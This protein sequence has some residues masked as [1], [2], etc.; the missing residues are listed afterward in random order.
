MAVQAA[1]KQTLDGTDLSHSVIVRAK[2][3]LTKYNS[4]SEIH[5]DPKG[6]KLHTAFYNEFFSS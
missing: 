1:A 5:I 4:V 6:N 2:E 3:Y